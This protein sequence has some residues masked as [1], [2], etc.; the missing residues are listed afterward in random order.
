VEIP[1]PPRIILPAEEPIT[2]QG[3]KWT[4]VQTKDGSFIALVPSEYEKLSLNMAEILRYVKDVNTQLEF[5]R[6]DE[7][8][9]QPENNKPN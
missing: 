2:L 8:D 1:K 4:V 3:V 5:Y 7:S 6:K 9:G